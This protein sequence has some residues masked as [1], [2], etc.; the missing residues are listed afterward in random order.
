MSMS[1][2][3]PPPSLGLKCFIALPGAKAELGSID[4]DKIEEL[5]SPG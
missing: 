1:P 2:I 3:M 4:Y 5:A